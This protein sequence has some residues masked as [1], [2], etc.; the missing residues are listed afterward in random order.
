MYTEE[1]NLSEEEIKAAELIAKSLSKNCIG[2][3]RAI[4]KNEIISKLAQSK[5]P[6]I[7]DQ[8][9]IFEIIQYIR[10]HNLCPCLI[11]TNSSYYVSTDKT[12][13]CDYISFL[14][15]RS[16]EINRIHNAIRQQY[17]E[18]FKR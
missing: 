7:V 10:I 6:I 11:E 17:K 9:K 3:G 15:I 5:N 2:K 14:K 18:N 16:E 4:H 8:S 1:F 12:E 13:V